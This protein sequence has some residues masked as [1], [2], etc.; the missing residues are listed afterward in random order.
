MNSKQ[1]NIIN[2]AYNPKTGWAQSYVDRAIAIQSAFET[3]T[4]NFVLV[5][6]GSSINLEADISYIKSKINNFHFV[7]YDLNQGKGHAIRM[8]VQHLVAEIYIYTDVDFPY[9]IESYQQILQKAIQSNADVV[10]GTRHKSYFTS[11]P[12]QRRLISR[13]LIAL[14]KYF[15][16]LPFPDSQAGIKL[17]AHSATNIFNSISTKGFLFEV[18]FLKKASKSLKICEQEVWL[19]SDITLSTISPVTLWKL[20]KEYIKL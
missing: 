17:I 16:R 18:E 12:F 10:I 8:G 14:N 5:N 2:S 13:A 6:D 7:T 9:S 1:I 11:I 15:F 3:N 20:F 4:L 19:R